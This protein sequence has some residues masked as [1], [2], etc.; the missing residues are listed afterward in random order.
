[1]AT[2]TGRLCNMPPVK[3]QSSVTNIPS[4]RVSVVARLS[5]NN[6]LK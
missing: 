3:F 6:V 2:V 5:F 4:K 1:V